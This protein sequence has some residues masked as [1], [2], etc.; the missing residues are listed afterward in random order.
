VSLPDDAVEYA[1]RLY[2][3]DLN[4]Y[5]D[6]LHRDQWPGLPSGAHVIALPGWF[7][8]EMEN[9]AVEEIV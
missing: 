5:A 2:R 9:A 8:A 6:C 4:R 1:R 3:A 7:V